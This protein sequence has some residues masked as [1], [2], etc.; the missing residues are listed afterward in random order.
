[1]ATYPEQQ[2]N[3]WVLQQPAQL[4][5][6]VSQVFWCTGV[7]ACWAPGADPATALPAYLE[8]SCRFGGTW[9]GAF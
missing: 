2:R 4:V 6:A 9:G 5:L 3:E 1:M 7:E 8:V